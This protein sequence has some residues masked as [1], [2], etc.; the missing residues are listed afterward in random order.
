MYKEILNTNLI[1]NVHYNILTEQRIIGMILFNNLLL[2]EIS[3]VK[4]E[5]FFYEDHKNI[6]ETIILLRS[7]MVDI[8]PNSVA[9]NMVKV[10]DV[11]DEDKD[12]ESYLLGLAE[13]PTQ[14]KISIINVAIALIN[15]WQCRETHNTLVMGLQAS[16][17]NT[18]SF[19]KKTMFGIIDRLTAIHQSVD[20]VEYSDFKS[21]IMNEIEIFQNGDS[22]TPIL[23]SGY[24]E[25]DEYDFCFRKGDLTI[26]GAYTG[27]G[28][29]SFALNV[30]MGLAKNNHPTLFVSLELSVKDITHR[31][32]AISS[33]VELKR[34]STFS[35][36]K[37]TFRA[38]D[39]DKL[40]D[41]DVSHEDNFN[42]IYKLGSLTE[43]IGQYRIENYN[44]LKAGEKKIECLVIDYIKIL[45]DFSEKKEK[46]TA[47]GISLLCTKLKEFAEKEKI[48]IIA[49]AQLNRESQK[50]KEG[51]LPSS[52]HIAD[53]AG[54]ERAADVMI[55]LNSTKED[56]N[57]LLANITKNR[58][59]EAGVIRKFDY[60]KKTQKIKAIISKSNDDYSYAKAGG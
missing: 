42:Q 29:T 30:A 41:R 49:L 33:D 56:P 55:I 37:S 47:Q 6:F 9:N 43:I 26:I 19:N 58:K 48:S 23:K 51:D 4:K 21:K 25:F 12:I 34:I 59:S 2:E 52:W 16:T 14:E 10:I 7:D 11:T 50:V 8:T 28:K 45:Y 54:I 24:H 5:Y 27:H 22:S 60:N 15:F 38:I 35:K 13:I 18:S 36:E 46:D 3:H 32:I 17:I 31:V 53:S 44:R 39:F 40:L 20:Q 57:Q 1:E